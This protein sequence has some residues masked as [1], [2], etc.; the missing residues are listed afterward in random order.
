MKLKHMAV[1]TLSL[2]AVKVKAECPYDVNKLA[3]AIYKTEGGSKAKYAYGI[4][5]IKY[6]DINDA[7]HICINTINNNYKRWLKTGSKGDFIHFLGNRYCPTKG[8]L[9][10]TEKRLNG[11]WVNNCKKFYNSLTTKK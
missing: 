6:K 1:L 11:N 9:S 8:N 4:R 5:S 10:L 2:I 7:R 3:T